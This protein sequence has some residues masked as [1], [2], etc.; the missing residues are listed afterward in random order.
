MGAWARLMLLMVL[1]VFTVLRLCE[2]QTEVWTLERDRQEEI[3][4]TGEI[5]ALGP[6]SGLQ[7]MRED[8]DRL[9]R[10]CEAVEADNRVLRVQVA[11]RFGKARLATALHSMQK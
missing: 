2:W 8:N 11:W 5:I 7:K 10:C 9:M 1:V 3:V 4:I 6:M